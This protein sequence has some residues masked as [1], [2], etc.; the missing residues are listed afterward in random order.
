MGSSIR[1]DDS[2]SL[3]IKTCPELVTQTD[4]NESKPRHSENLKGEN[5]SLVHTP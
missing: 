1:S 5:W 3:E 2:I 4:A